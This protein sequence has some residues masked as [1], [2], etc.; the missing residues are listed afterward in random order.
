MVGYESMIWPFGLM[1]P[2]AS[3]QS[4]LRSIMGWGDGRS[5][6]LIVA[7]EQDK[8]IAIP[9]MQKLAAAYR[10][11]LEKVLGRK[12]PQHSASIGMALGPDGVEF[13]AVKKSGHHLMNDLHW[14]EAAER[15]L[16]FL[17]QL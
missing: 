1:L 17:Q 4:V 14:D 6:M 15:I 5:M 11:A 12:K 16:E 8:L 10:A 7:G 3:A 13:A 9:L 2:F